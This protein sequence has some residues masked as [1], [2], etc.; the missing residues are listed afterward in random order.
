MRK[1]IFKRTGL[2]AALAAT[3]VLACGCNRE[4]EPKF[5]YDGSEF[6]ELGQ[7]K[8][9]EVEV[10]VESITNEL[11]DEQ[12]KM[13]MESYKSYEAID[14]AAEKGDQVS[15]SFSG[16]I[17]GT[18]ADGFSSSGMDY[19]VGSNQ[20]S[21]VIEGFDDALVG[22]TAGELKIVTL[23][24]SDNFTE[25]TEF[26]GASIVYEIKCSKV[27]AP[28]YPQITDNWVKETLKLDNVEAYRAAVKERIK[29][30]VDKVVATKKSEAVYAKV[31]DNTTVKK[32]PEDIIAE[33]KDTIT[34]GFTYY[35]QYYGKSVDEYVKDNFGKTLDEYSRDSAIQML[36]M[37]EIS[38]NEKFTVDEYYYKANLSDFAYKY[39][40]T[41]DTASFVA[42]YGKDYII[43]NM[44]IEKASNLIF[45]TAKIKE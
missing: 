27:K 26:T 43:N 30:S 8:D 36:I 12:I 32:E 28:V 42:E 25:N 44:I 13:D 35:A 2:V 38:K 39:G 41:Y 24:V 15:I 19:V 33:K 16:T 23:K 9:L 4:Y 14:R 17:Q 6:I 37:Q 34:K 11:I 22:L 1:H 3:A 31:A 40:N 10:D 5:Q 45:D 20:I 7:Y 29:E 18:P 21:S